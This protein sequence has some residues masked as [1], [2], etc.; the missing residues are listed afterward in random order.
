MPAIPVNAQLTA[1]IADNRMFP[2]GSGARCRVVSTP[3]TALIADPPIHGAAPMAALVPLGGITTFRP[4]FNP[5]GG[6]SWSACG[7]PWQGP[8]F[9]QGAEPEIVPHDVRHP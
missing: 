9:G 4:G 5:V 3:L 2:Q 7:S 1:A 8:G 6:A